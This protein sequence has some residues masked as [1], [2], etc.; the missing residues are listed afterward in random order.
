MPTLGVDTLPSQ[1]VP[2]KILKK[3]ISLYYM[4]LLSVVVV[5]TMGSWKQFEVNWPKTQISVRAETCQTDD[6][7]LL[8]DDA[9]MLSSVACQEEIVTL[10]E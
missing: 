3:S 2:Q 10:E 6:L 7:E 4:P 8:L 9:P 1:R 5:G